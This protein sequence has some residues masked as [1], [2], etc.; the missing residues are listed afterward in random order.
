MDALIIKKPWIDLILAG[1]KIWE[2]R[3]CPT[4][5]RG[6]IELIQSGSGLVIGCCDLIDCIKLDLSIYK[7]S[8]DKHCI[9]YVEVFPY[10]STFAWVIANPIRYEKPKPYKH[11]NG[12]VIWVKL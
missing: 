3:G 1:E 9:K 11:P 10:K 5:K 8:I 4:K 6:K 2:I 7:N 12:A